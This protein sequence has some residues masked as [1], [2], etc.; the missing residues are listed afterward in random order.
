MGEHCLRC[1]RIN[2]H[3]AMSLCAECYNKEHKDHYKKD[4]NGV[5]TFEGV[6]LKDT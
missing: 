2:E 1:G 3:E 5:W 6:I 4:R